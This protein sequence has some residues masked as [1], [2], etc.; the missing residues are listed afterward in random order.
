MTL[1]ITLI[2]RDE[3]EIL[4]TNLE[5]HF[6]QGVDFAIVTDHGSRDSTPEILRAY[7]EGGLA[8]VLR[9]EG[10]QHHQGRRVT[11]MARLA[12]IEYDADWVLNGDADEFWWPAAGTLADLFAAIPARYGQ[13]ATPRN[14]FIPAHVHDD[15]PFYEQLVVR[16]R[17]SQNLIGDPLEPKIAH[18]GDPEIVIP[19]GNHSVSGTSLA[20]MPTN[21]LIEVLHFPMRTFAQFER[22]VLAT[23]LGLESLPF[24]SEGVGR[25]QL[26]LLELQ[27]EGKL[28]DYFE[29]HVLSDESVAAGLQSGELVVDRRLATFMAERELTPASSSPGAAAARPDSD[30]ARRLAEAALAVDESV[31][32]DDDEDVGLADH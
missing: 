8:R 28:V 12:A 1:I 21:G 24:R 10:V 19:H 16:E 4:D 3:E 14:N 7:E 2:V 20:P 30:A 32:R 25:D 27:R 15:R 29:Q 31:E 5:Y 22:K 23:G 11:R 6:A 9:V 18:R 17:A 26:K 13:I